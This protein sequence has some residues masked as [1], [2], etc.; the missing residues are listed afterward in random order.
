MSCCDDLSASS[1]FKSN[2]ISIQEQFR[3]HTEIVP[4][5]VLQCGRLST[6]CI[7]RRFLYGLPRRDCQFLRLSIIDH[8]IA[9]YISCRDI[10]YENGVKI[11]EY[12][13]CVCVLISSSFSEQSLQQ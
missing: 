9:T 10:I 1:N 3:I 7:L 12:R 5:V 8:C 2:A 11:Y 13:V 6:V 4:I